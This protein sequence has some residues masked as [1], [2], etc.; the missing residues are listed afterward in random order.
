MFGSVPMA[1]RA[2]SLSQ[3]SAPQI[4]QRTNFQF[5]CPFG[6]L[7]F[8]GKHNMPLSP[9]LWGVNIA[10]IVFPPFLLLFPS[11]S[12]PP[13]PTAQG[14]RRTRGAGAFQCRFRNFPWQLP[15]TLF[16]RPSN[17]L[18]ARRRPPRI[19]DSSKIPLPLQV[20]QPADLPRGNP[21]ALLFQFN[22][23]PMEAVPGNRQAYIRR[24]GLYPLRFKP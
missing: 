20:P 12:A 3:H 1:S 5:L 13:T 6:T 2:S 22:I 19:A 8:K 21:A 9:G 14:S 24:P 11:L 18:T 17:P 7:L 10:F 16:S 15:L 4:G 23:R